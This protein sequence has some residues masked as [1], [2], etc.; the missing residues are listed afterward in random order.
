MIL[1]AVSAC[2]HS[3]SQKREKSPLPKDTLE[4]LSVIYACTS[5]D[6]C[7]EEKK[8]PI[9]DVFCQEKGFEGALSFTV[10]DHEKEQVT[11]NKPGRKLKVCDLKTNTDNNKSR[12]EWSDREIQAAKTKIF[13]KIICARNKRNENETFQNPTKS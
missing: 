12:C 3:K 8:G 4:G 9:A 1:L 2:T 13:S 7:S 11:G 6:D 10:V 5:N